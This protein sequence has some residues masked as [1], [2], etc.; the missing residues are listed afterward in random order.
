MRYDVSPARSAEIVAMYQ[1]GATFRAVAKRFHIG[2][3]RARSVLRKAGVPIRK[4]WSRK[5]SP[6]D[7]A[8][9]RELWSEGKTLAQIA[10][11]LRVPRG[12]VCHRVRQLDL[13]RRMPEQGTVPARM[14]I[15]LYQTERM[16]TIEVAKAIGRSTRSVCKVLKAY[17]IPMR[18]AGPIPKVPVE[19]IV[20]LRDR[21]GWTFRAIAKE[22]GCAAY[23]SITK[24]YKRAK[25]RMAA[26]EG[27]EACA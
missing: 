24:R 2:I 5:K 23:G 4:T 15:S 3:K 11:L 19:K 27:V 20:M 9:L 17:R 22:C 7:E 12:T 18:P 8:R 1:T 25:L 21:L 14:V 26:A 6:M 16:S 10:E 13:A